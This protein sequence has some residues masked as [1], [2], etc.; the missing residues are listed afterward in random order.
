MSEDDARAFGLPTDAK[1]RSNFVRL[2]DA[3]QNYA[4]IRDAEWFEKVVHVLDSGE[5]VPAATPWTPPR[6]NMLRRTT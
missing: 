5:A 3:K 4:P 1:A 6:P 2:D